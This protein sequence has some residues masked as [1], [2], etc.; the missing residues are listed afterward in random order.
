MWDWYN[1]PGSRGGLTTARAVVLMLVCGLIISI[2]FT[3]LYSLLAPAMFT[4]VP[5]HP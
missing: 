4:P 5:V 1:R 3:W 2:F